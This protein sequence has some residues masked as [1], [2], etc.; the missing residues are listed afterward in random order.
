MAQARTPTPASP[1]CPLPQPSPCWVLL[2]SLVQ[3][4]PPACPVW[5][6]TGAPNS[7]GCGC[8]AV[9]LWLS[10]SQCAVA[11]LG[12]F[13]AHVCLSDTH[14]SCLPASQQ[15]SPLTAVNCSQPPSTHP[16]LCEDRQRP[17]VR[18]ELAPVTISTFS[19]EGLPDHTVSLMTMA[20]TVLTAAGGTST[21]VTAVT[22]MV[23]STGSLVVPVCWVGGAS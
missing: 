14:A 22:L 1:R 16:S 12:L 11:P 9:P 3:P 2:P 19:L 17:G 23:V 10:P 20:M 7:C 13:T 21:T 6:H 8:R 4:E 5:V 18:Q 15:L